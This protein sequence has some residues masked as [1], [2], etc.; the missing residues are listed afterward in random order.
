MLAVPY[1]YQSGLA[2]SYQP[3]CMDIEESLSLYTKNGTGY[4]IWDSD[5]VGNESKDIVSDLMHICN[6]IDKISYQ[7]E[8]R[9][10]HNTIEE[11]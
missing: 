8:Q 7:V 9:E 6:H 1:L 5:N 10:L 11:F 4:C 3:S 2:F